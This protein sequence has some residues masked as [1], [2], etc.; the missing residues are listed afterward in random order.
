MRESISSGLRVRWMKR[1]L[2]ATCSL[3]TTFLLAALYE[4][5][6]L[7]IPLDEFKA[8][9]SSQTMV[10]PQS[11]QSIMPIEK[12]FS[13]YFQDPLFSSYAHLYRVTAECVDHTLSPFTHLSL[14]S[15]PPLFVATSIEVAPAPVEIKPILSSEATMPPQERISTEKRLINEPLKPTFFS[16]AYL[17]EPTTQR[18]H[19]SQI[20]FIDPASP[21]LPAQ[22]SAEVQILSPAPISPPTEII[23]TTTPEPVSKEI[24]PQAETP[25]PAPQS[26]AVPSP[27]AVPLPAPAPKPETL[28]ELPEPKLEETPA[29]APEPAPET[30]PAK[31]HLETETSLKTEDPLETEDPLDPDA[32][33]N[34][35]PSD[36]ETLSP[37][38]TPALTP[39]PVSTPAPAPI[40]ASAPFL[41]LSN[42]PAPLQSRSVD[43]SFLLEKAVEKSHQVVDANQIISL[44]ETPAPLAPSTTPTQSTPEKAKTEESPLKPSSAVAD[45]YPL[46]ERDPKNFF[47][48]EIAAQ[49]VKTSTRPEAPQG[50]LINFRNAPMSDYIRFVASLT[51]RNFIFREDDVQFFVSVVSKEPTSI[52]NVVSALLQE[53]RIH[54]LALFQQDNNFII[55]PAL[56][57]LS[58]ATLLTPEGPNPE[59]G[60]RIFQMRYVSAKSAE[61]I[62]TR[63]LSDQ[64]IVQVVVESNSLLITDFTTNIERAASIIQVIDTLSA[65]YDMGQYVSTNNRIEDLVPLA[66]KI[67]EPLSGGG[68]PPIFVVQPTTNSAF[69]IGSGE[70]VTKA[71][72]VLDRLD[73][74]T[75]TT[76]IFNHSRLLEL[77]ADRN[78]QGAPQGGF[79]PRLPG[80]PNIPGVGPGA[81]QTGTATTTGGAA[82]ETGGRTLGGTGAVGGGFQEEGATGQAR[83]RGRTF[84][85]ELQYQGD[86]LTN[87]PE[88]ET[89]ARGTQW[90]PPPEPGA[91]SIPGAPI[92][93]RTAHARTKF[94]I[95]KL[96]YRRGDQLVAALLSIAE[97]L[98]YDQDQNKL[99]LDAINSVQW[100]E[101]SNSII[102]TGTYEA[103]IKVKDLIQELDIPLKQVYLEMLILDTSLS[104]SITFSVDSL[105]HLNGVNLTYAQGFVSATQGSQFT[106]VNPAVAAIGQAIDTRPLVGIQGFNLG[107][108]GR[109][110]FHNGVSFGSIG[111]LVRALHTDTETKVVLNP[112]IVV[113]DNF[114]ASIFVGQNTAFQTQSIANNN[115]NI[116]TN[117]VEYRDVGTSL[118]VTPQIGNGNMITLLIDQ[119]VSNVVSTTG[120]GNAGGT[121]AVS[122][123]VAQ[124]TNKATTVTKVH[125]PDGNFVILSGMV[126]DEKQF[127]RSQMPCVGGIP[128]IGALVSS[129]NDTIAKRNYLIFIRPKIVECD[130]YVEETRR[131]QDMWEVKNKRRPRWKYEADEALDYLNLP[132]FNEP[133]D[134]SCTPFGSLGPCQSCGCSSGY[135]ACSSCGSQGCC[136]DCG[137][138]GCCECD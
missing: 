136:S 27:K 64:A 72:A 95:Y 92:N 45:H 84:D 117:N 126:R 67:L 128:F 97:S 98:S 6:A 48:K 38:P 56:G 110:I 34:K 96:D 13:P 50:H 102:I 81:P 115:G 121:Q 124:T 66:E 101:A 26:E 69:V 24:P 58:P 70:L 130:V 11:P 106:Q 35:D 116:L 108:I 9:S 1:L 123:P 18:T 85:E 29:P 5:S 43:T 79:L 15:L 131:N 60:T 90:T 8:T 39:T 65:A 112:K 61:A 91:P 75:G 94:Y 137:F 82:D 103:L 16:D 44:P 105:D 4:D 37:A 111:A 125:V 80:S 73:G 57:S 33:E 19:L 77:G 83:E 59:V 2:Y 36:A 134:F 31:T 113:E 14:T 17:Y 28:S 119:E 78:K 114:P 133:N 52:E 120:G 88:G 135:G 71:F 118:K 51:G 10:R 42:T 62:M 30:H 86:V 63:M 89:V 129:K 68:T 53:L 46:Y 54:G 20:S 104:E 107:I 21:S 55:Y 138:C 22:G 25:T 49:N 40:V 100:I 12:R 122:I 76:T 109:H 93:A 127:S 47:G 7:S 23:Q 41:V 3:P 74:K 132:R 99:L 32:L 87:T